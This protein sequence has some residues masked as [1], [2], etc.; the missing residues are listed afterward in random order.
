MSTR[1]VSLTDPLAR[2]IDD[3][4][5]SGD[6]QNASEVVRAGLRLL[7]RQTE[8]DALLEARLRAAIDEGIADMEAGRFEEVDDA[9]FE[10]LGAEVAAAFP[11]E[12]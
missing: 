9:W 6:F 5:R 12:E 11:L 1:N 3:S 10:A 8:R 7:K 4:V 2:F